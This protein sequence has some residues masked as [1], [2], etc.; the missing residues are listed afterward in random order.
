MEQSDL[1]GQQ[2]RIGNEGVWIPGIHDTA[3]KKVGPIIV[4]M[5]VEFVLCALVGVFILFILYVAL[6]V[7]KSFDLTY[8]HGDP[9]FP[10]D[11]TIAIVMLVILPAMITL[12]ISS[13]DFKKTDPDLVGVAAHRLGVTVKACPDWEETEWGDTDPT[14][15]SDEIKRI[16]FH[17]NDSGTIRVYAEPKNA[18]PVFLTIRLE[19]GRLRIEGV[20]P[21]SPMPMQSRQP[22]IE[23]DQTAG[24][25]DPR[26]TYKD[27]DLIVGKQS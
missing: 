16:I 21:A 7:D 17:V 5:I 20:Q 10:I 26:C 11:Q 18:E 12:W 4:G 22:S 27:G 25:L 2:S 24:Y 14:E 6:G 8:F 15:Y 23:K 9:P 3:K 19:A 1:A 13:D